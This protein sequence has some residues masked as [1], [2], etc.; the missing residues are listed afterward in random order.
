MEYGENIEY[1]SIK[2]QLISE[3]KAIRDSVNVI[4][5]STILA[6]SESN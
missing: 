4:K 6:T 3:N 1:N 5:P 2:I